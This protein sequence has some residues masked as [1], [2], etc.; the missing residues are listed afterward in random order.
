MVGREIL[1]TKGMGN[2]RPMMEDQHHQMR[3]RQLEQRLEKLEAEV[4][5]LK[6][7]LE[8]KESENGKSR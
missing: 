7:K 5:R 6:A 8:E 1:S 3:L 4:D 2:I